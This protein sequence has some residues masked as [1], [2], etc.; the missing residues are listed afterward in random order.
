[1]DWI[2]SSLAQSHVLDHFP[3]EI[4]RDKNSVENSRGIK[5]CRFDKLP[6]F[7]SSF[8][9]SVECRTGIKQMKISRDEL[10]EIVELSGATL[11][12]DHIQYKTLI[13]L[14]NSKR[15]MN[16]RKQ[17]ND[18]YLP[19]INEKK[20]YYCKPEFLFDS[21]IRHEVQTIEKYLW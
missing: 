17:Q 11:L 14:C 7:P 12:H 18:N 1:M 4:I 15:E 9:I 6:V 3:Y 21:I 19:R 2:T 16:N 10:I 13:V 20:V 8:I 5:Q